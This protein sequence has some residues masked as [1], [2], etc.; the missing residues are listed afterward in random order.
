[1]YGKNTT[2]GFGNPIRV[3]KFNLTRYVQ[4]TL[5]KREPVHDFRLFTAKGIVQ[6]LGVAGGF[7]FY[8]A[9]INSQFAFGR[10]RVG[11]GN[12]ATQRMRL[13]IIYTKI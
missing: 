10:V 3:W 5:T 4:N 7:T 8:A 12:H 11:G 2:D 9:P 13:R 6:R 1:M